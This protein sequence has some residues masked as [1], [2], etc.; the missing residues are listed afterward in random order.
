V[1]RPN[2]SPYFANATGNHYYKTYC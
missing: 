2:L 1:G